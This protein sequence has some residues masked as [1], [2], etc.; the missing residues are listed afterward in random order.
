MIKNGAIFPRALI[1]AA[2]CAAAFAASAHAQPATEAPI[3][4]SVEQAIQTAIRTNLATHLAQAA[5]VEA[6]GRVIQANAALLPQFIGTL[7]EQRIFKLNLA[8]DGFNSSPLIPNPVI[9]PYDIFDAR[10]QLVQ[11]LLDMNS[12]WLSKEASANVRAARWD[13]D[14]AAE[15]IAAAAA[16]AYIED[17]R[18]LQDV[19]DAESNLTLS[20]RLSTQAH[21]QHDAGLATAVDL[22]RADTRVAVDHENLIQAQL[23]AYLAELRL[24]RIVGL[25]L[26]TPLSLTDRDGAAPAAGPE[27]ASALAEA[28]SDRIELKMTQEQLKAESYG[29]AAAKSGYLPTITAKADY[30]FSGNVPEGSART[31]SVGGYLAFPLF[32]GGLTH[33][34]IKEARG[35][36]SAAQSQD[37]DTR[38]QVEEDIRTALRTLSAEKDDVDAAETRKE[39]AERELTLARNRYGTGAGDNIQVVSAQASLADALKAWTDARA[40]Y[41]SARVNVAAALGHARSFHL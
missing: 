25:P 13:E 9:G 31:G 33:G 29:L 38:I 37:D 7:S 34:Q 26:R 21:H 12:I 41:A 35:K 23:A 32:N 5:S 27:E 11:Q 3:A 2:A 16:L 6:R 24:K 1:R 40:R 14:L 39:L 20:L 8:I 30:G 19:D 28:Q 4:L 15:Q 10:I 18:A 17:L 36:K 22:A